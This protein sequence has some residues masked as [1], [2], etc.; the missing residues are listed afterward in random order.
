MDRDT[1]REARRHQHAA[2]QGVG[3]IGRVAR[4][5]EMSESA[6]ALSVAGTRR[7]HPEMSHQEAE[8]SVLRRVLGPRLFDAAYGSARE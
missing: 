7:R 2:L 4:A 1:S 8:A 6:R 5:F 3:G